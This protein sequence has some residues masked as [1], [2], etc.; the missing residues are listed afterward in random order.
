MCM[1]PESYVWTNKHVRLSL[2][3]LLSSYKWVSLKSE[4]FG[5]K[6]YHCNC[7]SRHANYLLKWQTKR[8][9]SASDRSISMFP[10][11]DTMMDY[12]F[13]EQH[14][15]PE[16]LIFMAANPWNLSHWTASFTCGKGHLSRDFLTFC[17]IG[18]ASFPAR[19]IWFPQSGWVW[20]DSQRPRKLFPLCLCDKRKV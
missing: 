20:R 2:S 12:L 6:I 3:P 9:H 7:W 4:R 13:T 15:W 16:N 11:F 18:H 8:L 5:V 19:K 17:V 1:R 14:W 10:L